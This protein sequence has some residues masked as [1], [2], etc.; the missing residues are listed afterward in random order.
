MDPNVNLLSRDLRYDVF[1]KFF[2]HEFIEEESV[3]C[4][5]DV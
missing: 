1:S 5:L 4:I 2:A 3:L